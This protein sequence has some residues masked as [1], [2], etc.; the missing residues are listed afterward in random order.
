MIFLFPFS[1]PLASLYCV[2]LFVPRFGSEH[3]NTHFRLV[4]VPQSQTILSF[5]LARCLFC[6]LL[7]VFIS[8]LSITLPSFLPRLFIR[9]SFHKPYVMKESCENQGEGSRCA[10]VDHRPPFSLISA[11]LWVFFFFS[12]SLFHLSSSSVCFHLI[13]SSSRLFLQLLP[14]VK[15]LAPRI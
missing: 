7:C 10:P 15:P 14:G 13:S 9:L 3:V 1:F 8:L 4:S 2:S 6:L 5:H 12:P 11:G